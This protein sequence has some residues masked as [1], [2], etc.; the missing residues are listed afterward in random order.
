M[1]TQERKQFTKELLQTNAGC[2]LPCW[3]GIV[4]GK[5]RW[6][7][8]REFLQALGAR[9]GSDQDESGAIFHGT[10][11]FD[12]MEDHIYNRFGFKEREGIIESVHISSEGYANRRGFQLLWARYSPKN[13]ITEYGPPSRVWIKSTSNYWGNTGYNGYLLWLFY[14]QLGFV[15][16]YSGGVKYQPIYHFCPSMENKKDIGGI[17]F[18]LQ[19]PSSLLPLDRLDDQD[20]PFR[21]YI[22]T[23][24][25]AAGLSIEQFY[26]LFTQGEKSGCFDVQADVFPP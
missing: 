16:K 25:E 6:Y 8:T 23:I 22:R 9:I 17:E 19:S 18:L 5:T 13:V 11:G 10:G 3:W 4:P 21:K 14:D 2:E 15:I 20:V 26:Q 12:L 1:T 7:V 24:E